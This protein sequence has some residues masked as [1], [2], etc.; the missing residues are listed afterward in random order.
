[1]TYEN[2]LT[3][4]LNHLTVKNYAKGTI[5]WRR[6]YL[7]I[8]FSYLQNQGINDPKAVT[9]AQ[10]ESFKAYLKTEYRTHQGQEL[11][12]SSFSSFVTAVTDFFKW[13]ER[14]GQILMTPAPKPERTKR[15]KPVKLP[16]VLNEDE[17][18][19]ILE[20]C[21]LNT[22]P[23][24]RDRAILE[25]FYSTGIRRSELANL[26]VED[27]SPERQELRINEGKGKKDRIVPIGEYAC[28]FTNAYLQMIRPWLA[29]SP[30]EKALFLDTQKGTRLSTQTVADIVKKAVKRSGI[31]KG[32][33]INVTPHTFRHTMATHLLR[34]H[35]DLRHIQAILGHASLASTEIYTHLTVENLKQVMKKAHPRSRRTATGPDFKP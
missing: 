29:K 10:V 5:D 34:N 30:D 24:L 4:Y 14:T 1:M 16:Q 8:F 31:G 28:L 15:L 11:A 19:K 20:S 13:L 9:K 6:S 7:R 3:D 32:R 25:M 26:N 17:V 23:G 12:D 18:L 27:Y 2:Y 33:I 21:P 35:A 22:P